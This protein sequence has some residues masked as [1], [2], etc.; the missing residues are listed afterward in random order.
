[1]QAARFFALDG[2]PRN[3]I[4]YIDHI[5]QLA[6]VGRSLHAL[7]QLFGLFVKQI[8]ARPSPFQAQIA[9][10]DADIIGHYLPHFAHILRNQYLLFVGHRP[11]IVP[12]GHTFIKCIFVDMGYRMF[13]RLF[14]VDYGF[15]QR[16]ACQPIAAVQARASTFTN[17]IQTIDRRARIQ[18]D[19]DT[20]A[21]VVC[22]RRNGNILFGNVYTC[23]LY[24]SDAADEL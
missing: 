3:E 7:K 17:R 8:Q 1:M 9:A 15:N 19:L 10:N 6:D 2:L 21:K 13:R 11:L 14:C 4:A 20:A 24:T 22:T 16:I 5:S 18:V 23:L 12:F